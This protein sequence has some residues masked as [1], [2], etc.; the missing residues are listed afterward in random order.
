MSIEAHL[1]T[2]EAAV[3][4]IRAELPPPELRPQTAGELQTALDEAEAGTV[5]KLNPQA[6]YAASFTWK[7]RALDK[8]IVLT[9]DRPLPEGRIDPALELATL[10]SGTTA[11][12]LT[13]LP[14]SH[15]LVV[16]GVRLLA[17]EGGYGD[18]VRVGYGTETD[19]ATLPHHLTFDRCVLRGD[20]TVGQKRGISLN[21]DDLVIVGCDIREIWRDGQD[22]QTLGGW[23]TA[24]R[25]L[26]RD[27]HLESGGEILM[28]GGS[29]A[30]SGQ[31][32]TDIL[33][34]DCDLTRPIAWKTDGVNRTVKNLFELKQGRNVVVRRSRL[35]NHWPA[36][37]SGWAIML[38]PRN[39]NELRDVTIEDCE[40]THV[41]SG[42]NVSGSAYEGTNAYCPPFIGLTIRH[43]LFAISRAEMGGQGWF[44]Q[45][46][47]VETDD[48]SNYRFEANTILHDGDNLFS[49]Y[50][51]SY[52][53]PTGAS[54][55]GKPISGF[56]YRQNFSR[57]GRYG[58]FSESSFGG[59]WGAIPGGVIDG[60]V[61]AESKQ[62][63]IL[64]GNQ[65]PTEAEF[66]AAF[67]DYAGGDYRIDEG[68]F[69]G[70]GR[71]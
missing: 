64:P 46:G 28:Y 13:A 49:F 61:L 70:I 68:A 44:C 18:I 50:R 33:I 39:N 6:T 65:F 15:H 71:R 47:S 38:A 67:V 11:S 35:S 20:P 12:C 48:P 57:T 36:A 66:Q 21:G 42:I 69:P 56:T 54:Q 41:S 9:S 51:G 8:P 52:D 53:D 63:A 40:I 16:A 31:I 34:E 32:A 55:P 60:N 24:G 10:R 2:I 14:G 43:C 23:N 22:N 58:F 27:C 37:Q 4:A 5:I 3:A 26:I 25:H 62:Q 45:I 30:P 1:Q 7:P 59:L 19:P 17:N 29:H